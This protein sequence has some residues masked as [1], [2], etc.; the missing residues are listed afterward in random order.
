MFNLPCRFKT[1][2][3][4]DAEFKL[5][6]KF[7]PTNR[8]WVWTS[9]NFRFKHD[10]IVYNPRRYALQMEGYV[11][12][13]G[14]NVIAG[15]G[16]ESCINPAHARLKHDG[17]G[18]DKGY[19]LYLDVDIAPNGMR[20]DDFQYGNKYLSK[21]YHVT[22]LQAEAARR[23][24]L[25]LIVSVKQSRLPAGQLSAMYKCSPNYIKQLREI[26]VEEFEIFKQDGSA[27]LY[28]DAAVDPAGLKF[29]L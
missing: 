25:E 6:I 23:A 14:R 13:K 11:I 1:L 19:P 26:T 22:L 12:P 29:K 3:Q 7:D 18:V 28:D 9:K 15:C 17:A 16:N 20:K 27:E 10:M 24:T 2:E 5:N 8:C 21:K 4:V